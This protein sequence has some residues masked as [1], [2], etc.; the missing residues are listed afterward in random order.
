M[1]ENTRTMVILVAMFA[2]MGLAFVAGVY[3]LVVHDWY[4]W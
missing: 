3:G 1:D 2:I 4:Q